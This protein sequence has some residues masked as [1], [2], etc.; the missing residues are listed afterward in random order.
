[1]RV[2]VGCETSGIVRRAFEAAGHDAWSIDVLP[3][4]DASNR[5]M[6]GDV[7]DVLDWDWDLLA[8]MHPPC[9]RLCKSGLRW[10]HGPPPG[11]TRDEMWAELDEAASL[12]SA[13]WNAPIPRVAVE[14]PLMHRHAQER[15][16]G[17]Q[18][19]TQRAAPWHHGEPVFK[20]V[21][22]WLRN[23]PP[24]VDTDRLTPPEKGT[25]EFERWSRIHRASGYRK[26]GQEP[27][28]KERSRFFPGIANAMADQ[29]GRL[30]GNHPPQG[31]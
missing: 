24:L 14:N 7:R 13:C 31:D 15:I 17:Y 9:T 26:A 30:G 19:F 29:W 10:L 11:K 4:E 5:H 22:L 8:V 6:V 12:F 28:W 18:P 3:S 16:V 23:L 25:A 2:L 1:M 21:C 20:D 27:R